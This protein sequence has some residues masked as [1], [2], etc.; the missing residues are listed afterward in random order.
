MPE[1]CDRDGG[2][3]LAISAPGFVSSPVLVQIEKSFLVLFF[4]KKNYFL[5]V[6][7]PRC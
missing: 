7:A 2:W 5:P 1:K 3:R 6:I 4:A